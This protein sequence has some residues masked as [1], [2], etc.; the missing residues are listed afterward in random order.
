[1]AQQIQYVFLAVV[2]TSVQIPRTHVRPN[3][4]VH[5]CNSC[6]SLAKWERET[7][8]DACKPA[9]LVVVFHLYFN[10]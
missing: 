8:S 9:S 6:V 5:I 4:V 7:F 2:K 10:K 3:M 1:M